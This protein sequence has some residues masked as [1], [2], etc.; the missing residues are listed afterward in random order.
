MSTRNGLVNL[1]REMQYLL[2][3]VF[4]GF[5]I[6]RLIS[7]SY[8]TAVFHQSSLDPRCNEVPCVRGSG[9]LVDPI[10]DQEKEE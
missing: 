4:F 10:T 5:R 6:G 8:E 9:F 1:N 3:F 2:H 7:E